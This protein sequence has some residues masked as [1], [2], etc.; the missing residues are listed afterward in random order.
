MIMHR[1]FND[2]VKPYILIDVKTNSEE[3]SSSKKLFLYGSSLSMLSNTN[4]V[5]IHSNKDTV[6]TRLLILNSHHFHLF[7]GFQKACEDLEIMTVFLSSHTSHVTQSLDVGCFKSIKQ[8]YEQ[9]LDQ[10]A[11][12]WK[13][14]IIK[15][16][17][18]EIYAEVWT[19]MFLK[20]IIKEGFCD[21]EL[22]SFNSGAVTDK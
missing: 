4:Y 22:V 13:E 12:L 2:K 9:A 16:Y 18:L 17:F 5:R 7:A 20:Q 6:V 8:Y 14:H 3:S 10:K 11:Y 1:L 21:A 19:C 15:K